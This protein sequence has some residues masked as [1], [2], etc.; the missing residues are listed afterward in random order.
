MST[1]H[2]DV[3]VVGAGIA[4]G[5]LATTL[6]RGGMSVVALERS[7][8]YVD[9]VRGEYMHPWGVAETQRLGLYDDLIAAGGSDIVRFVG[10]DEVV[11]P[12]EADATAF[13]LDTL[14]PG[15]PGGLSIGHPTAC[16]T[17]EAIGGG[18]RRPGGPRRRRCST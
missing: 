12:E 7:K 15:V 2:V 13:P 5:A 10:Y 1:E 14:L 9:H 4:G 17:I 11:A 18:C 3:V 16:R 8:E 6:A